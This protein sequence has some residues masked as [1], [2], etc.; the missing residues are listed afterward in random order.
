[1]GLN[2]AHILKK[3]VG[4]WECSLRHMLTR[5]AEVGSDVTEQHWD[6]ERG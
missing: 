1:M 2:K 5:W 6:S 4:E 3:K